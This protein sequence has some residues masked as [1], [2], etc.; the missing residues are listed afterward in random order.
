MKKTYLLLILLLCSCDSQ[1]QDKT[2]K[3]TDFIKKIPKIPPIYFHERD[4]T[5]SKTINNYNNIRVNIEKL[6]TTKMFILSILK[7]SSV[8]LS[9]ISFKNLSNSL[10]LCTKPSVNSAILSLLVSLFKSSAKP[11][12]PLKG[13]FEAGPVAVVDN[14]K[15]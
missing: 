10:L 3:I 7:T 9:S 6:E 4:E 14:G 1:P 5:G 13:V 8:E 12:I 2:E 15:T 11:I